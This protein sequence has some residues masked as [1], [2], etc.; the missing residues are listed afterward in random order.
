MNNNPRLPPEPV[1]FP[2]K[3]PSVSLPC[4]LLSV[5]LCFCMSLCLSLSPAVCPSVCLSVCLP[6]V[7][8][9]LN[10]SCLSLIVFYSICLRVYL[11]IN[12]SVCLPVHPVLLFLSVSLP[13]GAGGPGDKDRA[14]MSHEAFLLMANSQSD[15]DDWVRAIRRVIWAPFGGGRLTN[16]R[17]LWAL[18]ITTHTHGNDSSTF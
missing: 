7:R 13:H 8:L 15:M 6:P 3:T 17:S 18:D 12:P 9:S 5:S 1:L 16:P 10:L 4:V 2:P 11:C 14:A